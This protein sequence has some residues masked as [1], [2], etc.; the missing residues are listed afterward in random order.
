MEKF[1][2]DLQ[3]RIKIS[4]SGVSFIAALVVG[5]FRFF[6]TFAGTVAG[7]NDFMSGVIM[8]CMVSVQIILLRRAVV[9]KEALK[10]DDSLN[11]LYVRENDE[12][13][14]YIEQRAADVT[15]QITLYALII[16]LII[17]TLLN[18]WMFITLLV[19]TLAIGLLYRGSE[20]FYKRKL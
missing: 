10:D 19:V 17:S 9:A 14:R 3:F 1:K 20:F 15:I 2:K 13:K 6:P 18:E 4:L 5:V 11:K 16:G 12:R 7:M 8:G